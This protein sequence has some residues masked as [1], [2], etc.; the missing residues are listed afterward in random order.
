MRSFAMGLGVIAGAAIT[1]TAI[2]SLYPDVP[3]RMMRDGRRLVRST[4]RT[5]CSM[6][7][8]MGKYACRR[9]GRRPRPPSVRTHSHLTA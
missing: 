4:R 5:V 1:L 9:A 6:G 8:L 7:E 2:G 3:R